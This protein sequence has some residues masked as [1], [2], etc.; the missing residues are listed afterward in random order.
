M[1]YEVRVATYDTSTDPTF[2]RETV[3]AESASLAVLKVC[4]RHRIKVSRVKHV[5]LTDDN[6]DEFISAEA[7]A[8]VT[9]RADFII[10]IKKEDA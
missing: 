2:Y 4:E 1:T 3:E 8:I 9:M 10:K 7:K 5:Q 6:A